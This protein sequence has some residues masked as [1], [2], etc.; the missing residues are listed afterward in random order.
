MLTLFIVRFL[1]AK[2]QSPHYKCVLDSCSS[3]GIGPRITAVR[4]GELCPEKIIFVYV[5]TVISVQRP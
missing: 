4:S 1:F 3:D 5:N 2:Y